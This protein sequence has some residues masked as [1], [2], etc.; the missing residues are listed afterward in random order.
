[1]GPKFYTQYQLYIELFIEII[2]DNEYFTKW[3]KTQ[4][5]FGHL[6]NIFPSNNFQF[7]LVY[8]KISEIYGDDQYSQTLGIILYKIIREG[9]LVSKEMNEYDEKFF[10]HK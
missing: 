8:D 2:S 10:K 6:R 7:N 1:M 3:H 9:N 4:N 5:F